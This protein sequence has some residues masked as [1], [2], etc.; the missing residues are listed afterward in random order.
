MINLD[1]ITFIKVPARVSGD[2]V[3]IAENILARSIFTCKNNTGEAVKEEKQA[4]IE[5]PAE[6][7]YYVNGEE[8]I[9]HEQLIDKDGK[10]PGLRVIADIIVKGDEIAI[11]VLRNE[12]KSLKITQPR[13]SI[14]MA[15]DSLKVKT[16]DQ[17][18]QPKK[19]SVS[20]LVI[21]Y[22][23]ILIFVVLVASSVMGT[24]YSYNNHCKLKSLEK[25]LDVFA[26]FKPIS[27]AKV[28]FVD[29]VLTRIVSDEE[30][31]SATA[32]QS[33]EIK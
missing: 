32:S 18:P 5:L 26:K 17:P 11:A 19:E 4:D 21:D 7:L 13:P 16:A 6:I 31:A 3:H 2:E 23:V 10:A 25:K 30:L 20:G 28:R 9:N 1:Q 22:A 8:I 24:V 12:A 29:E 15:K 14:D 27:M 33:A